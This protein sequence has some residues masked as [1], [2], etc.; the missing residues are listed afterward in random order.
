MRVLLAIL[1][2]A[3]CARSAEPVANVPD[4]RCESEADRDPSVRLLR[5]K[6]A[7][8]EMFLQEHIDDIRLARADALRRCQGGGGP[9][10]GVERQRR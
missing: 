8:S 9:Q 4:P 10:G 7:G 5:I 1:L 6:A 2:L 3:G